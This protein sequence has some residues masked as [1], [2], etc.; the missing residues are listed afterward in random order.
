MGLADFF[1]EHMVPGARFTVVPTD[2]ADNIFEIHFVR[3]Q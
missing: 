2:R 3:T 1:A